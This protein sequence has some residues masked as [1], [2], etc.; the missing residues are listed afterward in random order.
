MPTE[1]GW[2]LVALYGAML[3]AVWWVWSAV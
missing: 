3:F 2:M 1:G